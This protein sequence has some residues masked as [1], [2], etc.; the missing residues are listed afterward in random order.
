MD[1]RQRWVLPL[2]GG[3]A[4]GVVFTVVLSWLLYEGSRLFRVGFDLL[5][6]S[7]GVP[8]L[9]L[10]F[11][12]GVLV[13]VLVAAPRLHPLVAG[14]PAIWFAIVFGGPMVRRSFIPPDWYPDWI[15]RYF[16]VTRSPAPWVILGALVVVTAASLRVPNRPTTKEG[17][18]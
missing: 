13:G 16:I 6:R 1:L 8:A 10:L 18:M 2:W 9:I 7:K 3:A 14:F 4:V 11:L 17:G 15:N 5:D 12:A